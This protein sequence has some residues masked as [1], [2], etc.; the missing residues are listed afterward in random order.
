MNVSVR[1]SGCSAFERVPPL[2]AITPRLLVSVREAAEVPAA[3]AGG[4]EILD[5][6]D[7]AAGSLG[8]PAPQVLAAVAERLRHHATHVPLS[9][10]WGDLPEFVPQ[11]LDH[12]P[13]AVRWVKVGFAG[14]R[15]LP[16][17]PARFRAVCQL[18]AEQTRL[19]PRADRPAVQMV[20]AAYADFHRAHAPSPGDVL[21]VA[22]EH[23][24]AGVLLDTYD[25]H[26][27]RL[28]DWIAP[29]ELAA[30]I[31]AARD[32]GLFTAVAGSLTLGD[33][34]WLV[35]LRPDIIAIRTAAC[36]DG[37]RTHAVDA[38]ALR[39]FRERLSLLA[40]GH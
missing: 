13:P 24:C 25:K 7:P 15:E 6:K 11:R 33:L 29:D 8:C 10:A 36:R 38:E 23:G 17:W 32:Y 20:A 9:V 39:R 26:A 16:D 5:V 1:L 37:Q 22:R 31:G 18:V 40:P 2:R 14:C 21:A 3:L 28:P 4:A 27:G 34:S 12:L 30:W 35:P 19:R